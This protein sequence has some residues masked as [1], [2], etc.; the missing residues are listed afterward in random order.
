MRRDSR[1]LGAIPLG[2]ER[3]EK[4]GHDPASVVASACG[5]SSP[6]AVVRL[7]A[8]CLVGFVRRSFLFSSVAGDAVASLSSC[9]PCL[10][11]VARPLHF[12]SSP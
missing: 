1:E 10:L 2:N 5:S 6:P 7:S 4:R 11:V 3:S 9:V 8:S 12:T